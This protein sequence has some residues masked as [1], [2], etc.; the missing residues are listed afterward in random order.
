MSI[1]AVPAGQ[2]GSDSQIVKLHEYRIPVFPAVSSWTES[3]QVP[4]ASSPSHHES[5][6]CRCD[7]GGVIQKRVVRAGRLD[8]HGQ[9]LRQWEIAACA[10]RGEK[11]S[12]KK[13]D[14]ESRARTR[15]ISLRV[16]I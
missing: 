7:S 15:S 9:A 16:Q 2:I 8:R 12:I 1:G 11:K 13:A 3:V 14:A 10:V 6:Y 5:R 4:P